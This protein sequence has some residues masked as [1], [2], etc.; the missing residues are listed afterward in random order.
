[1]L[2]Y[3]SATKPNAA[4]NQFMRVLGGVLALLSILLTLL[5]TI[6][7]QRAADLVFATV[8]GLFALRILILWLGEK[9]QPPPIAERTWGSVGNRLWSPPRQRAPYASPYSRS[10]QLSPPH[11]SVSLPSPAP[12]PGSSQEGSWQYEDGTGFRQRRRN[13]DGSA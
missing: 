7:H 5:A 10:Q 1:M 11:T 12:E 8:V 4:E 13:D 3:W 6:L 2:P 9:P